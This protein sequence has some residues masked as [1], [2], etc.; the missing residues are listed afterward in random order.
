MLLEDVRVNVEL[1]Y[2]V[3]KCVTYKA[4]AFNCFLVEGFMAEKVTVSDSVVYSA[5]L[6]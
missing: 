6:N 4:M 3:M 5:Q 1:E 2:K